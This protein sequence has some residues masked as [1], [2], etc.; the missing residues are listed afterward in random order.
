MK[1]IINKI[2]KCP[3]CKSNL[4]IIPLNKVRDRLN[5][6]KLL[7]KKCNDSFRIID[8][9]VCFKQVTE[10]D[11]NNK[12]TQK[13][14]KMFHN[15]ELKKEWTK[16]NTNK[17]LI[18]LN[19]EWQWMIKKSN[20]V[21][22]RIHLDWACGTGRF[23]RNI[24]DIV[25]GDIL[26]M[27]NDYQTCVGLKTFLKTIKKYSN[28]TIIYCDANNMGIANNSIDSVSTWHGLDE[29]DVK[30]AINESYRIL[31]KNKT[32]VASGIFFKKQSKSFQIAKKWKINFAKENEAE[33]YFNKVNFKGIN[34]K[35][36]Y[37]GKWANKG[38]F[39]PHYGD[40]YTCYAIGGTKI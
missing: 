19:K 13:M 14:Q 2:L 37:K 10:K 3:N 21:R 12:I 18:E 32:L 30:F 35:T 40:E 23:L 36:F 17:E 33:K 7:C 9:I 31:K 24:F 25:K 5:N 39:L 20:I 34:Y 29:P 38:D 11:K 1:Q 28:V 6:G 16:K 15:Q 8:S 4:K 27:D 26:V 22:S